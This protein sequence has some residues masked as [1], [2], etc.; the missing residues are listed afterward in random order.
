MMWIDMADKEGALASMARLLFIPSEAEIYQ[1]AI[2]H[3]LFVSVRDL[4]LLITLRA[5]SALLPVQLTVQFTSAS[6]LLDHIRFR[7]A[8]G[9]KNAYILNNHAE[10]Q[11]H[12]RPISVW[13]LLFSII[14]LDITFPYSPQM[15][16]SG[17][18]HPH[19]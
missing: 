12:N 14:C 3:I 15:Y 7:I 17:A 1:A 13:L 6:S 16:F 18:H 11:G 9:Y 2:R 10:S 8:L 5:L 4:R 19:I